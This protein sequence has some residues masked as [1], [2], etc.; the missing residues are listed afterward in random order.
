MGPSGRR[1]GPSAGAPALRFARRAP[2]SHTGCSSPALPG[3]RPLGSRGGAVERE[4]RTGCRSATEPVR[5]ARR[6]RRGAGHQTVSGLVPIIPA[7]RSGATARE[8]SQP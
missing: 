4:R 1:T 7:I 3:P 8:Y 5:G 6:S 2:C